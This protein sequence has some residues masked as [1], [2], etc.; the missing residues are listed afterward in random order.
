MA[1]HLRPVSTIVLT[2][3]PLL[4]MLSA[5]A[6]LSQSSVV[7]KSCDLAVFGEK[8]TKA[9]LTFFGDLHAAVEKQDAGA[10]ALLV[11]YPLRIN[12]GRGSFYIQD[13][14][15]LQSRFQE[16]FPFK[17][18]QAV[19][20]ETHDTVTCT[21]AGIMYGNGEVWVNTAG[22]GYRIETI[23][24]PDTDAP[25]DRNDGKVLLACQTNSRRIIVDTSLDGTPRYRSWTLGHSST[26]KADIEI[27]KGHRGFEGTGPC[28]HE[29]FT[30]T[31]G[32]T[33]VTL[34]GIGCTQD[35]PPAGA[36]ARL[37]IANPTESDPRGS[38]CF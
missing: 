25:S 17:I 10:I 35:T 36:K 22:R 34:E 38:W 20:S 12:N 24:L 27:L 15:S 6:S 18:R 33:K 5:H 30:F 21:Y 37:E 31:T 3:F 13:A 16:I 8:D 7:G 11:R 23:N 14:S 4:L 28:A 26:G 9:F 1:V 2:V 29:V 32:K 19:L